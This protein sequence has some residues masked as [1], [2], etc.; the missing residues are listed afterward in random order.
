MTQPPKFFLEIISR[1]ADDP[2]QVIISFPTVTAWP[3]LDVEVKGNNLTPYVLAEINP[4]S[5]KQRIEAS[6]SIPNLEPNTVIG[7]VIKGNNRRIIARNY[8]WIGENTQTFTTL[9]ARP[10][11]RD[12][13][14]ALEAAEPAPAIGPE[15]VPDP[16][17][18]GD[19][20]QPITPPP[21]PSPN[22]STVASPPPSAVLPP[23]FLDDEI[24]DFLGGLDRGMGGGFM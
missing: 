12:Y 15:V 16:L 18:P 17:Q 20:P 10:V 4:L 5:S 14:P 2:P 7:V 24:D 11:A 6:I 23:G 3:R 21:P 1:T 8:Y 19:E 13:S 22:P 9:T